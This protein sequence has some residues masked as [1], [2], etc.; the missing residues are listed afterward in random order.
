MQLAERTMTFPTEPG[1]AV[2]VLEK[3][4]KGGPPDRELLILA[5]WTLIGWLAG[6]DD[7]DSGDRHVEGS[8][9]E[10]AKELARVMAWVNYETPREQGI[11]KRLLL[12]ILPDLLSTFLRK[13]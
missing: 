13:K 7:P 10:L 5:T 2:A 3:Y 11:P 6:T 1:E 8:P 12:A 9:V 4:L